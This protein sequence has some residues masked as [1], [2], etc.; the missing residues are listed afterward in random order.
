MK[1]RKIL[2]V[3]V[4]V[5]MMCS[6]VACNSNGDGGSSSVDGDNTATGEPTP[7]PDSPTPSAS[8]TPSDSPTPSASPTPSDSPMPSD[9]PPL[10]GEN[11]GGS[12]S[13]LAG[14]PEEIIAKLVEDIANTG[15]QM[16]MSMPPMAVAAEVSQ[17]TIGL[18]E[19]DFNKYVA[20][21]AQSMAAI[22]TFAHQIIII[23]GVD[24]KAAVQIK[25]LVSG[26]SGY[27]PK[28]WICV[29]P[30][31]AIVV[32]SGSYV[33][34]VASYGEVADAAVEA[35]RKTAGNIGEVN[36]FWESAGE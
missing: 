5:V 28:K 15:A 27:D 30:E 22:G 34:L 8:P 31:K 13:G 14:T 21:A 4:V 11:G 19:A 12:G 18:S 36:T 20:A 1:T 33:L 9:S 35:F 23:Q 7:S 29:F 3:I 24:D 17:N 2:C 16:P 32:E 10:S 26:S 6:L 25:N